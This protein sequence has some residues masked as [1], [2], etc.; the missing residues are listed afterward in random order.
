VV[1]D[2]LNKLR[3]LSD[4]QKQ[5]LSRL[6]DLAQRFQTGAPGENISGAEAAVTY[7]AVTSK[8]SPDQLEEATEETFSKLPEN[9]LQD[10]GNWI[11]QTGG[12]QF[13]NV[14]NDPRSLANASLQLSSPQGSGA[15]GLL[16]SLLGGASGG[17]GGGAGMLDNPLVKTV[18][19][20]V[21]SA[22]MA[23]FFGNSSQSSGGGGGIGGLISGLLGGG[24]SSNNAT[25]QGGGLED[26]LGGFLGG[27]GGSG[28]AG[29][30]LDDI[31][32]GLL[33]GASGGASGS[34]GSGGGLDDIL[35]G[36]LGGA[37]GGGDSDSKAP[38]KK[39]VL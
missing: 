21:A 34:G 18:L 10:V 37:Q 17:S 39:N 2:K 22:A 33:G 8:L 31:L 38:T 27:A 15:D 1:D 13:A 5:G 24:D 3:N 26:I 11:R 32:G 19:A 12:E 23:K 4:E 36:L 30:G 9:E 35:G 25:Q 16:G 14:G 29:G 6:H 7:K 28:G 20:G